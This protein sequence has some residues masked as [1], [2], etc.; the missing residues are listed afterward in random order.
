MTFDHAGNMALCNV[1]NFMCQHPREFTFT[2][3][4]N[5]GSGMHGN[6]AARKRKGVECFIA[7]GEK[8]KIVGGSM[9]VA[10]K[11]VA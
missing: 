6:V 9:G 1:G 2:L 7:N 4:G 11:L 10:Y 5:D 8:L 3:R